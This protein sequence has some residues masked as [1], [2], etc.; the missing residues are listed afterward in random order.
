V[1]RWQQ[2]GYAGHVVGFMRKGENLPDRFN[3]IGNLGIDI[4]TEGVP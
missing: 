1:S 3:A 4:T 2:F